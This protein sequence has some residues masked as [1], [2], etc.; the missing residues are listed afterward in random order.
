MFRKRIWKNKWLAVRYE[1]F[2]TRDGGWQ[3]NICLLCGSELPLGNVFVALSL[4][5]QGCPPQIV[6]RTCS[7][8]CH[9][10]CRLPKRWDDV[11]LR[12]DP[13]VSTWQAKVEVKD[14]A[15]LLTIV[16]SCCLSFIYFCLILQHCVASSKCCAAG[17][18]LAP[19]IKFNCLRLPRGDFSTSFRH[20]DWPHP[21]SEKAW[22]GWR[23][24]T[25]T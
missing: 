19:D 14:L 18:R 1:M 5:V 22:M 9:W 3:V 17:S 21:R 11:N 23:G 24:R 7:T 16:S 4:E 2:R 20:S 13:P 25:N 8:L 12:L 6:L 15:V 10:N